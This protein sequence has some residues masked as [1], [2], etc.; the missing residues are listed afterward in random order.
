MGRGTA[1]PP[2]PTKSTVPPRLG[3][4]NAERRLEEGVGGQA[5]PVQW[6][7]HT[8]IFGGYSGGVPRR[9]IP[10]KM[11]LCWETRSPA[12]ELFDFDP[13]PPPAPWLCAA[14]WGGGGRGG[15]LGGVLPLGPSNL[16]LYWPPPPMA[17]VLCPISV[18]PAQPPCAPPPPPA[19]WGGGLG[20]GTLGHRLR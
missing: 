7:P 1:V 15:G 9:L 14:F 11:G 12:D 19:L 3:T 6:A 17:G 5:Q 13:P 16:C 18:S 8:P 2:S 10:R 20:L 4:R